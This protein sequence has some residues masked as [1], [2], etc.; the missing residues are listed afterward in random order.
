MA[1]LLI[2]H[3]WGS[4]A[5]RW[6]KVKKILVQQGLKVIIPNLPGFGKAQPPS[7]PWSVDDYVEW[8]KEL[9]E[10][11]NL[12]QFF[13]LGH[14][15]GGRIAIKFAIKYPQKISGLILS[16]VPA[17][18]EK[19]NIKLHTARALAKFS[20]RFSFL[21]FYNFF[22]KI[23][24]QYLL[25][26]TDYLQ[27]EGMMK[28]TYKRIIAEDLSPYLSQIKLKTLILWGERDDFVS[29]KLAPLIKDKIPN[30]KLIIFPKLRHSLHREIPENLA[31]IIIKFLQD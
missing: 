18:K 5:E 31:E 23:F 15:F 13:L 30:S 2:L 10:K 1:T 22:R 24:Y 25:R 20:S 28:E 14:S 7:Q 11:N 8:V 3:G 12:S 17:I 19:L 21:P 9:S 27:V 6:E 29:A 26:N 4:C 16:G